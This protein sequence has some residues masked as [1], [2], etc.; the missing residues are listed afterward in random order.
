M[1]PGPY[2]EPAYSW[3]LSLLAFLVVYLTDRFGSPSDRPSWLDG[4]SESA[5]VSYKNA[6]ESASPDA[7][8]QVSLGLPTSPDF[9][10][11]ARDAAAAR[12]SKTNCTSGDSGPELPE[13]GYGRRYWWRRK[14]ALVDDCL[15]HLPDR[16]ARPAAVREKQK[17]REECVRYEGSSADTAENVR[18]RSM[19][20]VIREFLDWYNDY[21]FA[22]LRF[23]DPDGEL[24]RSKME[25][26]HQPDYGNRYYARFKALEKRM[27]KEF[28]NPQ[29]AMLTFSG[30]SKNA[31]GEW[32]CIVDHLRDVIDAW[33]PDRGRGV[34]HALTDALDV[35][36]V[37][38]W[39]YA[40]A[41]EHH[42]SG[43]GHVH[44]GVFVDGEISE[45][46]FRPVIDKHLEVCDIAH[47]SGHDYYHDDPEK[48]PISV[49]PL[50]DDA[51]SGINNMA[52]YL[53]EYIGAVDGGE[54]FDRS[55][56]E[57]LFRAATWSSTTQR[58][59]FSNGA[60]ELIRSDRDASLP[61]P[62]VGA[63][64]SAP[65]NSSWKPGTTKEKLDDAADDPD[66]SP[67]EYLENAESDG[68][69]LEGVGRVDDDGESVF[70]VDTDT[71]RYL[72]LAGAEGLDPP[73]KYASDAPEA[74]G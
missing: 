62:G 54:L 63:T 36:E 69:S 34:Y 8:R 3:C 57:I 15:N 12:Q 11:A 13:T 14:N 40:V 6:C 71:V 19:S 20:A 21:R 53:A 64:A 2:M 70:E 26:S 68:W 52:S 18:S 25:N 17:I 28:D 10:K 61:E 5:I 30:S 38:R 4:I 32:R 48:K 23:K 66:R 72:E 35:P 55:P 43:Y 58:V 74:P 46:M 31:V 56:E 51:E 60:N 37:D 73:K 29:T 47:R 7:S 33:R 39:E 1:K 49:N 44:V 45:K 24:V 41:V 42:K 50:A 59:R 16:L 9:E 65:V 22:H 67:T 27:L